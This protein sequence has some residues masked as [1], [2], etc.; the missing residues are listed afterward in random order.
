MGTEGSKWV[1]RRSFI[2]YAAIGGVAAAGAYSGLVYPSGWQAWLNYGLKPWEIDLGVVDYDV[3]REQA[4]GPSELGFA[5]EIRTSSSEQRILNVAQW[6]DYWPGSV[7]ER[8]GTWMAQKWGVTGVEIRWQSNIYTS[9]EELFTWV[10]QTGRKFDLMYPTN[11]TV[12]TMEKAGLLVNLNLDWI[13]NYVN[14]FGKIPSPVPP[15]HPEYRFVQNYPTFPNGYNNPAGVDFRDPDLNVYSYRMKYQTPRGT[16]DI[17]WD[18][19][20]SLI[21][22]P[23]QWGTTGIGYRT[24][25][26]DR[27]DMERMGWSV[28]ELETYRNPN[29]GIVYDLRRKKMMLDDM[30]E[31][32]T[33]AMKEIGWKKQEDFRAQG[34]TTAAPTAIPKYSGPTVA[35]DGTTPASPPTYA[36]SPFTVTDPE[37]GLPIPDFQWSSNEIDSGKLQTALDWLNS[38]RGGSWGFNTPQ[39]GPWLVSG[40][41]YVDQAWSGDIMYAVQPNSNSFNPVDYFVPKQGG[42]RWIDNN[43]IHRECEKLW[44]AHEFINYICDPVTQAAVSAWNLYATPNAWSFQLLHD[45]PQYGFEGIYPNPYPTNPALAGQPYAYN[46]AEDPNIYSDIAYGYGDQPDELP[47]LN[48]CEY[49]KDIGVANTLK[50]FQYWRRAKF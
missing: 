25:V 40:V 26:F 21:A 23:Y 42:A 3:V 38:F 8:F 46:M 7:L 39:Q 17:T 6:Y 13:P 9:N 10:S 31:V 27:A 11:Y 18:E 44:L 49:Q 32:F 20:N 14:T 1:S 12:E 36:E 2:K 5:N 33:A 41:M 30:R 48:R 45:D 47:I 35:P 34:L 4:F 28:F 16:D 15:S 24:D 37:T 22:V 43:T 29:T 50:Y 19:R